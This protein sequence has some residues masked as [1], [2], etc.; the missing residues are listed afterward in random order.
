MKVVCNVKQASKLINYYAENVTTEAAIKGEL[1]KMDEQDNY[2]FVSPKSLKVIPRRTKGNNE[3][4]YDGIQRVLLKLL[5][6]KASPFSPKYT[7]PVSGYSISPK[8][9]AW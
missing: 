3:P 6:R 8:Y 1:E 7:T 9:M 2:M 5:P 4:G